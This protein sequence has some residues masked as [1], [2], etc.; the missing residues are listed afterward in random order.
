MAKVHEVEIHRLRPTQITVGMIEV[1]DK[2]HQ[3]EA[4]K[5]H[6]QRDVMAGRPLAAKPEAAHT[7]RR[8]AE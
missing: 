2:R 3:L 8:R 4:L 5:K 7:G 1:H 6:E